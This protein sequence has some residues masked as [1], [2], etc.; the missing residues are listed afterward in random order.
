M[1]DNQ[2]HHHVNYVLIFVALIVCTALSV[3]FD[4]IEMNYR[5]MMVL[6]LGVACAKAMFVLRYFMHLKFEG[7]WKYV[8]L[9]PTTILAIGLPL[10]LLPDVGLH[11]YTQAGP[12]LRFESHATMHEDSD[13]GEAHDESEAADG[14]ST[15]GEHSHPEP[16]GEEKAH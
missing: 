12:Q 7:N 8:L 11:Y 14:H 4:L 3:A 1:S 15:D 13:H 2:G 16:A 5:L 10:A 6:V 9:L